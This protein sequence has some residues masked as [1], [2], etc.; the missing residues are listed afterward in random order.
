MIYSIWDT[1]LIMPVEDQFWSRIC[2][3]KVHNLDVFIIWHGIEVAPVWKFKNLCFVKADFF[4][5]E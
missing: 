3:Q 2:R 4:E 1:L 5:H